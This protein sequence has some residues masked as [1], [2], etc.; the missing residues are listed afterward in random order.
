VT[1]AEINGELRALEVRKVKLQRLTKLRREVA[2]LEI[3]A[4]AGTTDKASIKIITEE[5]CSRFGVTADRLF[6]RDRQEDTCIPRQVIFFLSRDLKRIPF[7]LTGRVFGRNH[8]TVI[9]GVRS[10]QDR[11]DTDINFAAAVS[12][13]AQACKTRLDQTVASFAP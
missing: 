8:G 5:V 1:D 4:M 7:M 11:I 2:E 13:V 10:I 6:S 9:H 3:S 12:E